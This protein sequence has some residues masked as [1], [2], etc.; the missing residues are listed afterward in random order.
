MMLDSQGSI[1]S[2]PV[3][4]DFFRTLYLKSYQLHH[5]EAIDRFGTW[6]RDSFHR[7]NSVYVSRT[8]ENEAS[9]IS[10]VDLIFLKSPKVFDSWDESIT[11][12]T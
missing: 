11:C 1:R 6:L 10:L 7:A 5:D 2:S 4:Q 3:V 8:R 9:N 12:M